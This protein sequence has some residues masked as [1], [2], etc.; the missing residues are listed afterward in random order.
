MFKPRFLQL[1]ETLKT[2]AFS[3]QTTSSDNYPGKR[4]YFYGENGLPAQHEFVRTNDN[5]SSASEA[6][7]FSKP[8]YL[9]RRFWV[10]GKKI[11]R[12]EMC[13]ESRGNSYCLIRS[14]D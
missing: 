6:P 3:P 13:G 7:N 11:W 5:G 10:F 2:K 12:H 8:F 9:S 14:W 1:E 4:T